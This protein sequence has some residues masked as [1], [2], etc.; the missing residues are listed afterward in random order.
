MEV[1][2]PKEKEF[3]TVSLDKLYL[4][5]KQMKEL[6]M[7]LPLNTEAHTILKKHDLKIEIELLNGILHHKTDW[8]ER[9]L[10]K[11]LFEKR[12]LLLYQE[13]KKQPDEISEND[14]LANF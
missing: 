14:D 7:C 13:I 1:H 4:L 3:I 10:N 11:T 8:I 12:T 6:K 5:V 2:K 9:R